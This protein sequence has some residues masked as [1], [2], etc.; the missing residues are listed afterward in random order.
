MAEQMRV[1]RLRNAGQLLVFILR[2][3]DEPVL[4]M[5]LYVRAY[6][7]WTLDHCESPDIW[8]HSGCF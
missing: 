2:V 5:S 8:S 4:C 1:Q 6:N 7:P 3:I